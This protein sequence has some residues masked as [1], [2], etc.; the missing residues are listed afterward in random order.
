MGSLDRKII[1]TSE[2]CLIYGSSGVADIVSNFNF[3][4]ESLSL[5]LYLC[6]VSLGQNFPKLSSLHGF[7]VDSVLNQTVLF[8]LEN[9]VLLT[10]GAY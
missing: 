10:S 8:L 9:V 6:R 4:N 5:Y 3:N 2:I 1:L 7:M